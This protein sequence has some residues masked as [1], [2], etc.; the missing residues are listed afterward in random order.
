M[1]FN[2]VVEKYNTPEAADAFIYLDK[3]T[4]HLKSILSSYDNMVYISAKNACIDGVMNSSNWHQYINNTK[5]SLRALQLVICKIN[6]GE[7]G[8]MIGRLE[9]VSIDVESNSPEKNLIHS[10]EQFADLLFEYTQVSSSNVFESDILKNLIKSALNLLD[11]ISLI[12]YTKQYLESIN[13]LI[14]S[15]VLEPDNSILSIRLYNENL[16]LKDINQC[17]SSINNIYER[18]CTIFDVSTTEFPLKPIKIESGSLSEKL[19]GNGKVTDFIIDLFNRSIDFIYRNYTREGKIK[20]S[21]NKIDLLKKGIELKELCESH[22]I[23]TEVAATIIEENMNVI[24]QDVYKVTT[25]SSKISINGNTYDIS[26]SISQQLLQESKR[27][28]EHADS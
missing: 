5:H 7:L 2:D 6:Q 23:N 9:R 3:L 19:S 15:P 16:T 4:E 10:M 22:G 13:S 25:K 26:S 8:R 1:I 21:E 18:T 24:L 12:T 20:G 14:E 11:S 17:S 27:L 28:S